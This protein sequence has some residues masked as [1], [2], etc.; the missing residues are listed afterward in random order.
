MTAF[1]N[2]IQSGVLLVS[3]LNKATTFDAASFPIASDRTMTVSGTFDGATVTLQGSND[4][5]N[6]FA[7]RDIFGAAISFAVAG[8]CVIAENPVYVKPV[9]T[10]AGGSTSISVHIA[11]VKVGS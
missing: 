7:L 8:I 10:G 9:M 3:W 11:A 2:T 1:S 5:V 6:Y 4:G